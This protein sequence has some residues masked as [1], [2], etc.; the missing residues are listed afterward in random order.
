MHALV[1]HLMLCK[2]FLSTSLSGGVEC[3]IYPHLAQ[4]RGSLS[5]QGSATRRIRCPRVRLG[6]YLAEANISAE[7]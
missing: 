1:L 2:A 6:L 3:Q 4:L 5:A 7:S